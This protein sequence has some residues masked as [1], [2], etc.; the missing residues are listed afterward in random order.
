MMQKKRTAEVDC[1]EIDEE[2]SDLH[3]GDVFLPLRDVR[4]L[5]SNEQGALT[6]TLLP[7]AA[8]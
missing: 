7:P 8:M 6:Q 5:R 3:G 2:L 1:D 4:M